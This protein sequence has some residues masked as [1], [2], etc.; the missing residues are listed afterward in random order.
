MLYKNIKAQI[1]SLTDYQKNYLIKQIQS[2]VALNN[3]ISNQ[4]PC[5][6]PSCGSSEAR[7]IKRGFANGKQRYQCKECG[8]R[9]VYDKNQLTYWSH[10]SI[11][12]WIIAIEDTLSFK[13]LEETRIKIGV[14][15]PTMFNIRHKILHAIEAVMNSEAETDCNMLDG[16]IEADETFVAESRKGRKVTDRKPRRH[17]EGTTKRGLSDEQICCCFAVDHD[18][19]ITCRSVNRAKPDSDDIVNALGSHITPESVFQC[20]GADSYNKLISEKNCIK[21]ELKGHESYDKVHH[22]NTVNGL[23]SRFK[24]M[25]R[26]YRGIATRYIN[27]YLSLFAFVNM[28]GTISCDELAS[29]FRKKTRGCLCYAKVG[30]LSG[31]NI[32]AY[33]H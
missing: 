29:V 7:F 9:F 20:D 15:H 4:R 3:E 5:V 19:H 2:F 28:M 6:C 24:D 18:N 30:S 21:Y 23:H 32:F 17:G 14:S 8:S 13:S 33:D 31:L 16:L 1:N 12:Q 27:R 11:D 10:L 22:L 26:D 25:Y